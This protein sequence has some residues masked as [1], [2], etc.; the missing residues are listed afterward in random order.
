MKLNL[1]AIMFF[2][3][4]C[5]TGCPHNPTPTPTPIP[6]V[7]GG[8]DEARRP[9]CANACNRLKAL[10]C[11]G[12]GPTPEGASCIEVCENLVSAGVVDFNLSCRVKATSCS[13]IDACGGPQ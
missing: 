9:T 13:A 6:V 11:K 7:D 8:E 4:A 12:S 1:L 2:V 10:G 5:T 3:V